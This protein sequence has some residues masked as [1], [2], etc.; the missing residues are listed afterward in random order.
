APE[1]IQSAHT[2]LTDHGLTARIVPVSYASHCPHVEPLHAELT[3][4]TIDPHAA[5]TAFYS[6]TRQQ[7]IPGSE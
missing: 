5:S 6:S 7:T 2:A 1:A 3:G 4:V